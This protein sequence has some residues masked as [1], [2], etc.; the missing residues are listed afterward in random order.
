MNLTHAYRG[1]YYASILGSCGVEFG[2]CEAA[3]IQNGPSVDCS[4]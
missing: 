4:Y 1:A 2:E 3:G